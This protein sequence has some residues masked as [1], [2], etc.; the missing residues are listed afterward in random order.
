M[1]G[2]TK[3]ASITFLGAGSFSFQ[4]LKEH[5]VMIHQDAGNSVAGVVSFRN[6]KNIQ[7]QGFIQTRSTQTDICYL[8]EHKQNSISE[9]GVLP[10]DEHSFGQTVCCLHNLKQCSNGKIVRHSRQLSQIVRS[11][12]LIKV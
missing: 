9:G 1:A 10:R 8:I 7:E 12:M 4:K 6:R 3:D 2:V 5:L 11:N